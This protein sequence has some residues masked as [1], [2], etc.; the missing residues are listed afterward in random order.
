MSTD[1]QL[2]DITRQVESIS[3]VSNEN[4]VKKP[5]NVDELSTAQDAKL[6]ELLTLF[7]EYENLT[8]GDY[9]SNFISGHMNLSRSNFNSESRRF[10][11]DSYDLRPYKACKQ[12]KVESGVFTIVDLLQTN[13]QKKKKQT[14]KRKEKMRNSPENDFN[15]ETEAKPLS[16]ETGSGS[17]VSD[18]NGPINC[19]ENQVDNNEYLDEK[20]TIDKVEKNDFHEVLQGNSSL[21]Q[22]GEKKHEQIHVSK[23]ISL[24]KHQAMATGSNSSGNQ[25]ENQNMAESTVGNNDNYDAEEMPIKDPLSQFGSLVPYQLHEAQKFFETGLSNIIDILNLQTKIINLINDI[26]ELDIKTLTK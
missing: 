21:K 9:R 24:N 7:D 23:L 10:G 12:I 5:S 25:H 20:D 6:S 19:E 15:E 4:S 17:R 2:N 22:R 18:E 16:S 3:I 14:N 8:N 26:E 1:N 13:K 11:K